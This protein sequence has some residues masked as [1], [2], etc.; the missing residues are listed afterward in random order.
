MNLFRQKNKG[1]ESLLDTVLYTLPDS[2][3]SVSW[4]DAVEGTLVMGATG[5]GKSSGAANYI[6]KAMLRH[7]FGMCIL[8]SKK[9][10]RANWLKLIENVATDRLNDVVV[11]NKDSPFSF[12]FLEYEMSRSGEGGGDVNAISLSKR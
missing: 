12:N 2:K 11:F 3:D 6:A 1:H 5:S 4:A 8:C 9:N 10:E 7:Q